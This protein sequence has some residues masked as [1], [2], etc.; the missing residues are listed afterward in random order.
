MV[1]KQ[2]PI[3]D[4][5]ALVIAITTLCFTIVFIAD[6]YGPVFPLLGSSM[7][8]VV[9]LTIFTLS[10]QW[11][12]MTLAIRMPDPGPVEIPS[13]GCGTGTVNSWDCFRIYILLVCLSLLF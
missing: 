13:Y 3:I 4:T 1:L 8:I 7:W 6:A 9:S 2:N 5:F 10:T 11:L 12:I